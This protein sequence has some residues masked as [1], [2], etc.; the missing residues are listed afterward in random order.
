MS[1]GSADTIFPDLEV[2]SKHYGMVSVYI[3]NNFT[4][5]TNYN[6][7]ACRSGREIQVNFIFIIDKQ[8]VEV[9]KCDLIK[10][11]VF[12][13]CQFRSQTC[14]F[15]VTGFDFSALYM[16]QCPLINSSSSYH[17]NSV[18]QQIG[19]A[20]ALEICPSKHNKFICG[21]HKINIL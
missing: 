17:I 9:G 21:Q 7:S 16:V 15:N 5:Y 8:A 12:P 2:F 11:G 14:S 1:T 4:H 20:D 6:L 3:G 10:N 18:E 13:E 19:P